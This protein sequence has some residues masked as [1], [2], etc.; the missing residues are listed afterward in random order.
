MG[1]YFDRSPI[2]L[3]IPACFLQKILWP[4]HVLDFS[5]KVLTLPLFKKREAGEREEELIP[6][7]FLIT[8]HFI[9]KCDLLWNTVL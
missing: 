6:N 2:Q 1:H 3:S 9:T 7:V 5:G 8:S 4:D